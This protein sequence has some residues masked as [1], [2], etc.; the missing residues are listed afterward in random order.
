[1]AN[2]EIN[3]L[4][5]KATVDTTDELEIQETGG[6]SSRKTTVSG[7]RITQSQISDLATASYGYL[8]EDNETG[9]TIT[10]TYADTYYGWVTATEG[11]VSG[12]GTVT[13]DTSDGTADHLTIGA[14]GAGKYVVNA[15][16]TY[17]GPSA[18]EISG[19]VHVNGVGTAL[20]F[21]TKMAGL[22]DKVSG[23]SCGILDLSANDEVSLRFASDGNGD[24]VVVYHVQLAIHRASA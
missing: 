15:C 24:A 11:E 10:C 1:M 13:S 14:S 8:Y 7:L 9:S 5:L 4:T 21:M 22:G 20:E 18:A 12:S 3:D 19:T 17:S 23:S 16:A 2:V 6:G